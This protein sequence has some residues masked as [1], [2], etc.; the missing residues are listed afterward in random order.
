[1]KDGKKWYYLTPGTGIMATGWKK[2]GGNWYFFS[3][4]AMVT[5]T[6]T[7]GGTTYHFDENGVCQES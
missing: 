2:I 5:G 7:I 6:K 3:N 4:G 1:M